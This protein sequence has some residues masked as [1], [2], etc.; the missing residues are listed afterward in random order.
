MSVGY[1]RPLY[2][3]PFDHRGSFQTGL[4]G[5]K[6]TLTAE[7]TARVAASKQVVYDA[8][9][10]A[11]AGGV[12]KD[13]RRHPRGRAVRR[14]HPRR[15]RRRRGSSRPPRREERPGRVRLRVRRRLRPP[16]RGVEPDLLQGAGPLQPRGRRGAERAP[17]RAPPAALRV[18]ARQRPA[19]HVRAARPAEPAQLD[20]LGGDKQGRTT[21]SYA[22]AHGAGHSTSC[23]TPGSSRTSGRSRGSTAGRIARRSSPPRSAMDRTSAA[24]S[25]AAARTSRRSASG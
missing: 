11:V 13:Q 6:G 24:S 1:N 12:P 9:K 5:W 16:H 3:L 17:G 20:R 19:V 25:W 15:R 22:P 18:P 8:F 14:G 4:F 23:R 10:A 2:I 21:W 7:Q